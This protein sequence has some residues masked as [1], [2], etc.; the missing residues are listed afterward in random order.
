MRDTAGAPTAISNSVDTAQF[1]IKVL[2]KHL[3]D[4][5]KQDHPRRRIA[6]EN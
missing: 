3:F 5:K 2:M 6:T 1:Q 4:L